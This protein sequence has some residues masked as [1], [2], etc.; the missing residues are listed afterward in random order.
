MV[1]S[2]QLRVILCLGVRPIPLDSHDKKENSKWY[3]HA[4]RELVGWGHK[5]HVLTFWNLNICHAIKPSHPHSFK[6]IYPT[7]GWHPKKINQ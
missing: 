6:R 4:P 5:Y 2:L 7:L 3:L 1:C